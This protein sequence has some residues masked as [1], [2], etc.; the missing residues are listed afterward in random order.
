MDAA[1]VF[2]LREQATD[3]K[4]GDT[5]ICSWLWTDH[6]LIAMKF[7]SVSLALMPIPNVTDTVGF[8]R[9]LL[10]FSENLEGTAQLRLLF[11][12]MKDWVGL[13]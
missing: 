3:L 6:S 1:F 9:F 4:L 7:C 2:C 11:G 8:Q 10:E 5:E 13:K 12:G